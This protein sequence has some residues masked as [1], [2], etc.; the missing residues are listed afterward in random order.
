MRIENAER[1]GDVT[2]WWP[3]GWVVQDARQPRGMSWCDFLRH[4]SNACT[5][6]KHTH[7]R[8][9]VVW[10]FFRQEVGEARYDFI[11]DTAR[12]DKKCITEGSSSKRRANIVERIW[13]FMCFFFCET[14][15]FIY[16]EGCCWCGAATHV[17]GVWVFFMG[18]GGD[19][20]CIRNRIRKT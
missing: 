5:Q 19:C 17:G 1:K 8:A 11:E 2:N 6:T 10:F 13:F 12:R 9:H 4:E 7:T 14:A 20:V 3:G 16:D 15:K 18:R